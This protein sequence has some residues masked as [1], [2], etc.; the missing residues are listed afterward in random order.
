MEVLQVVCR[1]I[2]QMLTIF[3]LG[4]K[5]NAAH[6]ICQKDQTV[7]EIQQEPLQW[8]CNQQNQLKTCTVRVSQSQDSHLQK[9]QPQ[10]C[11][12]HQLLLFQKQLLVNHTL[13]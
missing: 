9:E 10:H 1:L 8:V 2:R 5:R 6:Q 7:Q 12:T 13:L 3:K 11:A 4:I